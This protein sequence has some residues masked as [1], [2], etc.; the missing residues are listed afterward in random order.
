MRRVVDNVIEVSTLCVIFE[1]NEH[2]IV[3]LYNE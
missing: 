3:I 2:A 1:E